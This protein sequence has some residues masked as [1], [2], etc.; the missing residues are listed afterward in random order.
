[1][2]KGEEMDLTLPATS[3]SSLWLFDV[4]QEGLVVKTTMHPFS[5]NANIIT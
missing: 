3:V 2:Q 1:M 4:E 5:V